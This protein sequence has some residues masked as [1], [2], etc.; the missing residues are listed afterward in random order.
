[1]MDPSNRIDP[2]EVLPQKAELLDLEKALEKR[3]ADEYTR[4]E[5]RQQVLDQRAIASQQAARA[6][7]ATRRGV[8]PQ[9]RT[10]TTRSG[11]R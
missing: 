9:R 2:D 10:P 6:R 3:L 1:M 7:M 8:T 5:R 11:R 4:E